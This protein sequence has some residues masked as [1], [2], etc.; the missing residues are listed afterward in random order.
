MELCPF[1]GDEEVG[2]VVG[3]PNSMVGTK[4]RP[5]MTSQS[6]ERRFETDMIDGG[7]FAVNSQW[8]RSTSIG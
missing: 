6:N 2:H 5:Y 7:L 3:A 4:D 1:A 8:S